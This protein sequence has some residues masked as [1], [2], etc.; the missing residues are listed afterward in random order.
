MTERPMQFETASPIPLP[1][2]LV[3]NRAVAMLLL[4][5]CELEGLKHRSQIDSLTRV[6][7]AA[8]TIRVRS[9]HSEGRTRLSRQR[10]QPYGAPSGLADTST[11]AL[12]VVDYRRRFWQG[13]GEFDN[14][15]AS[16][17]KRV[18]CHP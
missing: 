11:W 12:M 4:R 6:I 2:G 10:G 14:R 16:R 8:S 18:D 17:A 3:A 7:P 13:Y 1:D 5:M 9:A 15:R